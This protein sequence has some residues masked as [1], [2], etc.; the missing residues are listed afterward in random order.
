VRVTPCRHI[1]ADDVRFLN[2]SIRI[3]L[4]GGNVYRIVRGDNK[5]GA[6]AHISETEMQ[7]INP[8]AIIENNRSL[9]EFQDAIRAIMSDLVI[10]RDNEK[11]GL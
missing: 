8:K 5:D 10:Q 11:L 2:E 9:A 6:N 7:Y 3:S 4:F 1:V